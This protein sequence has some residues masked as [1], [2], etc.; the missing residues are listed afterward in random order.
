MRVNGFVALI[1]LLDAREGVYADLVEADFIPYI[2]L[3]CLAYSI[4]HKG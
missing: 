2:L 3:R 1:G 4:I